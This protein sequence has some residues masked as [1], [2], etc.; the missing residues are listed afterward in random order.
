MNVKITGICLMNII[1]KVTDLF[2]LPFHCLKRNWRSSIGRLY[3]DNFIH[4]YCIVIDKYSNTMYIRIHKILL[5]NSVWRLCLCI[6]YFMYFTATV[7]VNRTHFNLFFCLCEQ[8]LVCHVKFYLLSGVPIWRPENGLSLS[9]VC[10][11]RCLWELSRL[12]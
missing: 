7:M 6:V 5:I 12:W 2:P 4:D 9:V 8:V 11:V 1:H 10:G 3:T